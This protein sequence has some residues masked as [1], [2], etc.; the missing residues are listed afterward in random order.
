MSVTGLKVDQKWKKVAN[1]R[2]HQQTATAKTTGN[3]DPH[4]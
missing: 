2:L 3:T 4:L 1:L